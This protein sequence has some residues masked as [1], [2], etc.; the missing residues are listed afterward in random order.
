MPWILVNFRISF[1]SFIHYFFALQKQYFDKQFARLF[2][3]IP[4]NYAG[5]SKFRNV[6]WILQA[7]FIFLH[8]KH[9]IS[10]S[11]LLVC[12][13]KFRKIMLVTPSDVYTIEFCVHNIV[14]NP[15]SELWRV[16]VCH[17]SLAPIETFT[18]TVTR[19]LCNVLQKTEFSKGPT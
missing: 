11:C 18:T 7:L 8:Y 19:S 16:V 3:E 9:N 6:P 4:K 2:I 14:S 5:F 1:T 17:Q 12:L 15:K 13:L 10:T